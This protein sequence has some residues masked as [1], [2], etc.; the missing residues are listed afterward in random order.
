MHLARPCAGHPRLLFRLF[1]SRKQRGWP[2]QARARGLWRSENPPEGS[3]AAPFSLTGQPWVK[4]GHDGLC[5]ERLHLIGYRASLLILKFGRLRLARVIVMPAAAGIH[6]SDDRAADWSVTR[7]APGR[8]MGSV[9]TGELW[10]RDLKPATRRIFPVKP[11]PGRRA[12]FSC[13]GRS[14]CRAARRGM[15]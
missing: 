11:R 7:P 12:V 14:R 4:P 10:K 9:A 1:A 3:G 6:R 13:P 15:A 5:G 8:R 2:G